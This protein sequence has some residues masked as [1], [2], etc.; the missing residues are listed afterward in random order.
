M[1]NNLKNF[2][3]KI[4]FLLMLSVFAFLLIMFT[5]NNIFKKKYIYNINNFYH[6]IP[7]TIENYQNEDQKKINKIIVIENDEYGFRNEKN[8]INKK[9]ILFLGDSLIRG[10]NTDKEK[11]LSN[12][13]NKEVYNAGMDGF[14]TLNSVAVT[15]YLFE[16]KKFKKIVLF[17]NI[18]N[19]FRDNVF[20]VEY[21]KNFKSRLVIFVKNNQFLNKLSELR[22]LSFKKNN[23]KTEIIEINKPYFGINYLKLLINDK[24]FINLTSTKTISAL[25]NLR[26]LSVKNNA[27]LLILGIPSISEIYKDIKKIPNLENELKLENIRIDRYN[28]K[29]D[30][31]NPKKLFFLVCKNAGVKCEYI[32]LDIKSYYELDSDHWNDHGQQITKDFL[33]KESNFLIK[34]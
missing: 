31:E 25:K 10:M 23:K 16:K 34:G 29:V 15:N 30:F 19:D 22:F 5:Y 17:F 2:F 20:Q 14:S 21:K 18:G 9:S 8:T 33:I 24:N 7:S 6:G 28:D 26:D 4:V 11:L 3:Y 13:I 1:K 27:E 32:P 12:I